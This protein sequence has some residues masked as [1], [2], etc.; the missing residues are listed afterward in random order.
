MGLKIEDYI[1]ITA[2]RK[3]EPSS[4]HPSAKQP[5]V[6]IRGKKTLQVKQQSSFK[7]LLSPAPE[8][9]RF[10]IQL[11]S[12][13]RRSTNSSKH[14]HGGWVSLN[15]LL[16]TASSRTPPDSWLATK[17]VHPCPKILSGKLLH[18][19]TSITTV[20]SA[21][22]EKRNSSIWRAP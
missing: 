2:V 21:E 4:P 13:L 10:L 18:R 20:P 19:F 15:L 11:N 22:G 8:E 9:N 3:S 7:K 12:A 17:A 14:L 5:W 1:Y 6:V 16:S